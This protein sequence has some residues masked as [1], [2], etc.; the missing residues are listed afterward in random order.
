MVSEL[1]TN[2]YPDWLRCSRSRTSTV[3]LRQAGLTLIEMLVALVLSSIIFVSAYQVISNLVQYQVRAAV[4]YDNHNDR[5]LLDNLLSQIIEKGINQYDLF[6][7]IQ[8][9]SLFKGNADSLQLLS[10]AYSDRFDKPGHRVYRLYLRDGEM[11]ITYRAFG[12]E[13][14]SSTRFDLATGLRAEALQ[15]AYFEGDRWVDEWNDER[16]IPEFIRVTVDLPGRES[17][18]WIRATS[19]R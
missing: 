11:H 17:A 10:R 6:Y 1:M 3:L 2:V 13:Y 8:K 14:L 9:S 16:S 18:E 19:R 5:M 4:K 12:R 7:R 15:F